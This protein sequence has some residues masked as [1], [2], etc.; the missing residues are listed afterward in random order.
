MRFILLYTFIFCCYFNTQIKAQDL[1]HAGFG[2]TDITYT[3]DSMGL[4]GYGTYNHRTSPANPSSSSIH[5]RALIL[6][7]PESEERLIIIHADLGGIFH[8]MH[9]TL[10]QKIKENLYPD[11]KIGQLLISASHTHC[12][13]SGLSHYPLYMFPSPGFNPDFFDFIIDRMYESVVEA[14]NNETLCTINVKN[15]AFEPYVPVAFNR[16]LSAYNSNK[17]IQQK[18]DVSQTNLALNR[19]MALMS[20]VDRNGKAIGLMNWFGVHPNEILPDHNYISGASKGYAAEYAEDLLGENTVA[21]FAQAAAG[22][23]TTSDIHNHKTFDKQMAAIL[24][25]PDYHHNK[26][27]LKQSKWNGKIQAEKAINIHQSNS[28]FALSGN[29]IDGELI[30]V[31][32][33]NVS[34][35]E[36]F[37][38]GEKNARTSSPCQGSPFFSGTFYKKNKTSDRRLLNFMYA[39]QKTGFFFKKPFMNKEVKAYRKELY[40]QQRPKKIVVD[41]VEKSI[42]GVQLEKYNEKGWSRFFLKNSAKADIVIQEFLRQQELGALEEHTLLPVILPIQII[43]IGNIA[44]VGLPTEITTIA[45]NRLQKTIQ[46]TLSRD[47]VEAVF[48]TSNANEYAGYTTTYE[49]YKTQRYEGGHTL[50]GRHQ[51]GAFQTLYKNLAEEMTKPEALRNLDRNLSHPVFSNEELNK[52]SRLTPLE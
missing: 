4:W 5:S 2:K 41:A 42:F 50:Y 14:K 17:D 29:Q 43:R 12:A 25:E 26:T 21:I 44:I 20:F 18:Y 48:I 23:V 13:P 19:D 9:Q 51:L 11:F 40:R 10:Y 24:D 33:S 28:G 32:I 16:A 8:P 37:S 3:I 45:H 22:D 39:M 49:E 34:V 15:G 52:R 38:N 36:A 6:G 31:N 7:T 35:E 46:N 1:Y 47:G 30:Y 27:S